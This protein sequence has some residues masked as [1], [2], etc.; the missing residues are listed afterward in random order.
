[1]E[2]L[3]AGFHVIRPACFLFEKSLELPCLSQIACTCDG[4]NCKHR[5]VKKQHDDQDVRVSHAYIMV[6]A[7]SF[8]KVAQ[9]GTNHRPDTSRPNERRQG[10][11]R[12][13]DES[14]PTCA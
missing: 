2:P 6:T 14:F 12:T 7:S 8:A 9:R 1:M 5:T 10:K 13:T 11:N 3:Q 4:T